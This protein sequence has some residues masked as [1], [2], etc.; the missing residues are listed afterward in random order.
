MAS[1]LWRLTRL[2]VPVALG[3]LGGI[4]MGITD[5]IVVG[6]LAPM[7]FAAL[8][9][10]WTLNGPALLGG[11]GLLLGVQV[12]AARA[13]GAGDLG[14]AGAAWRKGLVIAVV[15]GLLILAVVSTATVPLYTAF[16]L[17]ESLIAPAASFAVIL[18][19]S[20]PL[21]LA[22][23][24][25][26]NFLE[27]LQRPLPGAITMWLANILNLVLNLA[28]VMRYGAIGSAWSTVLSRLFLFGVLAL[29]ILASPALKPY[30][31]RA[32]ATR[33]AALLRIGIAAALSAGVEAGAFAVLGV[34][35]AR[36]SPSAVAAFG[37]ATGGLVTLIGM[38]AQGYATAGTVL[39]SDAI[40]RG[41]TRD[42]G[43]LGWIAVAVIVASMALC[44]ALLTVFAVPVA[45]LFTADPATVAALAGVM[46]LVGLL[47]IPDGAQAATDSLLRAHGDNWLPTLLRLVPF[48]LVAPPLAFY[49][50]ESRHLGL[51]GVFAALLTASALAFAAQAA[52]LAASKK[53]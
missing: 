42:A 21:M 45:H 34:I 35:A 2:A 52:R 44:G 6:Q 22:A 36:G 5:T 27:A 3:R 16:G 14:A 30:R 31:A 17:P 39:V 1:L 12:L 13:V 28:L 19:L 48:V 7:Q 15:A 49:L 18:G 20:V 9:L 29:Y 11:F 37:I 32:A 51:F 10:G 8:N 38:I 41:T 40:G 47:M 25:C 4:V 33:Y 50:A 26:T 24:A 23:Q 46:L 53:F 43:R